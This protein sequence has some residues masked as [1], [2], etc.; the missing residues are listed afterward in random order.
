MHSHLVYRVLATG[1]NICWRSVLLDSK[2][3]K[4]EKTGKQLRV[5]CLYWRVR[6]LIKMK[7]DLFAGAPSLLENNILSKM[8]LCGRSVLIGEYDYD[9]V[10]F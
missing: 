8:M 3:L 4:Q 1:P 9:T 6:L 7:W 5:F 10:P 2:A